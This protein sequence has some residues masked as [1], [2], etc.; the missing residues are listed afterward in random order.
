VTGQHVY[1]DGDSGRHHARR[2]IH[3]S[4]H[5]FYA[6][7]LFPARHASPAIGGVAMPHTPRILPPCGGRPVGEKRCGVTCRVAPRSSRNAGAASLRSPMPGAAC[8]RRYTFCPPRRTGK[9]RCLRPL[10]PALSSP[11][12]HVLFRPMFTIA[13]EKRCLQRAQCMARGM[14]CHEEVRKRLIQFQ[15]SSL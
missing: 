14:L 13:H 4:Q 11:A 3:Y 6:R 2:V 9:L 8:Y 5:F 15:R 7:A 10:Q 1:V 12:R